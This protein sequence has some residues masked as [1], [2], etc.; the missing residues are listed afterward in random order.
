MITVKIYIHDIPSNY[1]ERV[2]YTL[3]EIGSR[4]GTKF[5]LSEDKDDIQYTPYRDRSSFRDCDF[6][7]DKR[8]YE[9][10][11]PSTSSTTNLPSFSDSPQDS[12]F[13]GYCFFH[14]MLLGENFVENSAKSQDGNFLSKDLPGFKQEQAKVAHVDERCVEISKRFSKGEKRQF[15]DPYYSFGFCLTH[16]TDQINLGNPREIAYN[17]VKYVLRHDS[18]FLKKANDG[19]KDLIQ[20]KDSWDLFGSWQLAKLKISPSPSCFYLSGISS[21]KSTVNDVRS[22]IFNS[23]V[24]LDA[25]RFLSDQGHEFGYHPCINAKLSQKEFSL[26]KKLLQDRLGL[27]LFGVRHH[28]WSLDWRSPYKTYRK[29]VNAGFRYDTS[30]AWK[31]IEGFRSGTCM[32]YKTFDTFRNRCLDHYILPTAIMDGHLL[33][34]TIDLP[35]EIAITAENRFQI[36]LNQVKRYNGILVVDWHTE[37]LKY[38]YHGKN[39][40]NFINELIQ[41]YISSTHCLQATPWEFIQRYHDHRK[42]YEV[43]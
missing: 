4:I 3:T 1:W 40:F 10:P 25:I 33:P 11:N 30:M 35:N 12:D 28:Y 21:A 26:S 13:I 41:K 8:C 39:N 23:K 22:H 29:H 18:G 14:L 34:S 38:R 31:D 37:C 19:L 9:Q 15:I 43:S 42:S 36:I 2:K 32:P 6:F 24:N 5:V 16:D 27:S 7:F 20:K 17:I